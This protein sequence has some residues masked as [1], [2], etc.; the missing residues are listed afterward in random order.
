V[1]LL[2]LLQAVGYAVIAC[3]ALGT[4]R[5]VPL[6]LLVEDNTVAPGSKRV[7]GGIDYIRLLNMDANESIQLLRGL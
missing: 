2:G 6:G 1:L 5:L 7:S 4:M 3:H